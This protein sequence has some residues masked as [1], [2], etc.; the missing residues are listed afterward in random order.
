VSAIIRKVIFRITVLTAASVLCG[1]GNLALAQYDE[2]S[3]YPTLISAVYD[4]GAVIINFEPLAD[5]GITYRVYR[6]PSPIEEGAEL[7]ST[8]LVSD[9]TADEIPFTDTPDKGGEYYYAVTTVGDGH[10][11]T[12]LVP[13]QNVTLKPVDYSPI[14]KPVESLTI[15]LSDN[16]TALISFSPVRKDYIYALYSSSQPIEMIEKRKPDSTL[17]GT[18]GRFSVRIE[19]ETAYFFLITTSN[20]LGAANPSVVPGKNTNTEAFIA[21]KKEAPAETVKKKTGPKKVRVSAKSLMERNLKNNFYRGYY[22]RAL[23]VFNDILK[24]KDLSASQRAAVYFY[25]GQCYYYSRDYDS[26]VR[27]FIFSKSDVR[28]RNKAELWIERCLEMVD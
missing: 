21:K 13:F 1:G 6:S 15:S 26:A 14:P 27:Y 28:Y 3:L 19:E 2:E 5:P 7:T 8:D 22:T 16:L 9:I 18:E 17:H 12:D 25:M 4:S 11:Y 20:R 10:E 24:H 23:R